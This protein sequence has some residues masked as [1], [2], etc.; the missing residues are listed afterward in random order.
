MI[1]C[2]LLGEMPMSLQA[3]RD[4]RGM[5]VVLAPELL[6]LLVEME[7]VVVGELF[8]LV[9]ILR[10]VPCWWLRLGRRDRGVWGWGLGVLFSFIL[11]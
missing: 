5:S 10:G 1:W 9:L 4:S 2:S 11:I 8:W 7:L 6:L 3:L